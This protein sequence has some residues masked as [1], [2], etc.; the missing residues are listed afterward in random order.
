MV[1]APIVADCCNGGL[2]RRFRDTRVR[3]IVSLLRTARSL[4]LL[5]GLACHSAADRA[6]ISLSAYV[7]PNERRLI[8]RAYRRRFSPLRPLV[9]PVVF[10]Q[11]L[12]N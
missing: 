4:S 11:N 5:I 6:L 12:E 3:A 9:G 10:P 7:P 2:F 1:W 8:A